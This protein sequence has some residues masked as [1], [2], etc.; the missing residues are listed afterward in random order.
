MCDIILKKI[1]NILRVLANINAS[2]ED[3]CERTESKHLIAS[4][5][6]SITEI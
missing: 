3:L 5:K 6:Y 2:F 4:I 1:I